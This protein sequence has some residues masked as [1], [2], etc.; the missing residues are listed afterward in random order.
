MAN[1]D[2]LL[3][4]HSAL[5]K[6]LCVAKNSNR[7]KV[8]RAEKRLSQLDTAIKAGI[9]EYRY[10]RIEN[11]YEVPTPAERA[12]LAKVFRVADADVFQFPV[13]S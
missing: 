13:A 7:L 3:T 10:W 8:L 2:L 11:G 6:T 9:K 12:A 4:R 5:G 1:K